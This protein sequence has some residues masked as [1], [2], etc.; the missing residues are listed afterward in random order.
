AAADAKERCEESFGFGVRL[1][2]S[3]VDVEELVSG[4]CKLC[5][6]DGWLLGEEREVD[7]FDHLEELVG[8]GKLL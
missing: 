1:G 6:E 4:M 2:H 5:G 7:V 8:L 3:A